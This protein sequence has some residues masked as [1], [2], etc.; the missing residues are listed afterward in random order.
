MEFYKVS[1]LM[2]FLT[3]PHYPHKKCDVTNVYFYHI[4]GISLEVHPGVHMP[5]FWGIPLHIHLEL[6]SE[7][8]ISIAIYSENL[9][10]PHKFKER[11]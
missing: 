7:G 3:H 9:K 1:L 5:F 11:L 10:N 8:P 2:F 4:L 6:K